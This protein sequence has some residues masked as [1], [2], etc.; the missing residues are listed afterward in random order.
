VSWVVR[1]AVEESRIRRSG[2]FGG[3]S[4]TI[5]KRAWS[6]S[7][8]ISSNPTSG[9]LPYIFAIFSCRS[10]PRPSSIHLAQMVIPN[11]SSAAAALR[12]PNLGFCVVFLLSIRIAYLHRCGACALQA[13]VLIT[14]HA[15]HLPFDVR[16][17]RWHAYDLS[18]LVQLESSLQRLRVTVQQECRLPNGPFKSDKLFAAGAHPGSATV[19]VRR[20]S[21]AQLCFGKEKIVG[22][23]FMRCFAHVAGDSSGSKSSRRRR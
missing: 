13:T 17:M 3:N 20:R 5:P 11:A 21:F 23:R 8:A 18:A 2:R 15:E 4:D 12:L 1:N 16:G 19:A 6:R 7:A 22:R 10:T 14:Q 9:Q